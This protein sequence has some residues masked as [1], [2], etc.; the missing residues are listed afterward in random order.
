MA[1]LVQVELWSD[2]I[3]AGGVRTRVLPI[4]EIFG[5]IIDEDFN[6]RSELSLNVNARLAELFGGS[7]GAVVEAVFSQ[8]TDGRVC[9]DNFTRAD[10]NT[11]GAP[12]LFPPGAAAWTELGESGAGDLRILS[13]EYDQA[14]DTPSTL[15]LRRSDDPLPTEFI[16]QAT[17]RARVSNAFPRIFAYHND[18]FPGPG[19]DLYDAGLDRASGTFELRVVDGGSVVASD[20]VAVPG[21]VS[22]GGPAPSAINYGVRLVGR[23]SGSDF[24][25]T[26]YMNAPLGS[27]LSLSSAK[28]YAVALIASVTDVS[29]ILAVGTYGYDSSRRSFSGRFDACGVDLT[30]TSLSTGTTIEVDGSTPVAESGGTAVLP[31]DDVPIPGETLTLKIGSSI[32]GT[33]SPPQGLFGGDEYDLISQGAASS[34]VPG[35]ERD[36]IRSIFDDGLI[37]EHRIA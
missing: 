19:S 1:K 16:I 36:V 8:T 25:L 18:A 17:L 37:L 6:G 27:T 15:L 35:A 32:I 30:V 20:I 26:G 13:N 33:L 3:A 23:T 21:G 12:V 14:V 22:V 10:S 11:I 24:D 29:P 2:Y 7:F 9:Q 28:G 34:F 4:S 5:A 31:M